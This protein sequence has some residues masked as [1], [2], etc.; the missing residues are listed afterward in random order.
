[1]L[2]KIQNIL[3]ASENRLTFFV[4]IERHYSRYSKEYKFIER[5]YDDAKDAFRHVKRQGGERYF[6]HL[7]AVA[8]ILID[9]VHIFELVNLEIPA[10]KIVAAALLHDIVEDC[11]EWNLSR[12]EK[13]YDV[14]VARLIDYVSKRP[15][16]DF[17]NEEEQLNFYHSRFVTAPFEFFLIKLADRLHNQL[18]LW[19]CDVEKIR[20]KMLETQK[21]YIPWA[22]RLNILSHELEAT[23]Q[24]FEE[25]IVE[26]MKQCAIE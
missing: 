12:I 24:D 19:C 16:K 22:R 17:N 7:R 10:Y 2:A 20:R 18:T 6:E 23:T 26:H 25:R 14:D 11:P 9:Y 21:Y 8:I 3:K 4:R 1:M 5:A 15:K 13:K